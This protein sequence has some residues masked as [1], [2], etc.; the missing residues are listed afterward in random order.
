MKRKTIKLLCI[1]LTLLMLLPLAAFAGT[2]EIV[3]YDNDFYANTGTDDG[4]IV[5]DLGDIPK[6]DSDNNSEENIGFIDE[7][8]DI[9]DDIEADDFNGGSGP[10][11]ISDRHLVYINGKNGFFKP[12]D[13]ITRGESAQIIYALI[14]DKTAGE[15]QFTDVSDQWYAE[16]INCLAQHGILKGYGDYFKPNAN[17]SRAEFVTILCRFYEIEQDLDVRFSDVHGHWAYNEI[18]TALSK[19]WVEGYSDGTFKPNANISRAEAVTIVNRVLGRTG[20]ASTIAAKRYRLFPDVHPDNWAYKTIMEASVAHVHSFEAGRE[21][22]TDHTAPRS[23]LSRGFHSV[24]VELYHVNNSFLFSSNTFVDGLQFGDDC[25]YTS[26]NA[27]LDE[28]ARNVMRSM[29]STSDSREV[30]LKKLFDYTKRRTYQTRP[31][32]SKGTTGWE[33][34]YALDMLNTGKGNCFSFT[35][36]FYHLARRLGYTPTTI[37]G[38][39]ANGVHCWIEMTS[40]SQTLVYD[41]QLENRYSSWGDYRSFYAQPYSNLPKLYVK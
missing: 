24:G 34:S 37:I 23:T 32:I 38:T 5:D 8:D 40:G 41:P 7:G 3:V 1:M 25:K 22:W 29:T 15:Q 12:S 14:D 33:A 31:N 18:A 35:A 16:P 27:Q 30:K 21:V 2:D 13:S 39:Y 9:V 17:I 20:D 28:R 11:L 26:G 19:G 10:A 36:T 4:N 6:E